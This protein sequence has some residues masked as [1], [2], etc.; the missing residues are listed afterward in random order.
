[1]EV[2]V[3]RLTGQLV[4]RIHS[5]FYFFIMSITYTITE[6][7][8][9]FIKVKYQDGKEITLGIKTWLSK[10]LIEAQIR[11]AYNEPDEGSVEDI[12]FKVG[13]TSTL[14][15]LQEREK[16]VLNAQ[17]NSNSVK[18]IPAIAMRD[19]SY[20]PVKLVLKAII[21][22]VLNNDKTDL[23]TIQTK[24]NEVDAKYPIENDQKYTMAEF[25]QARLNKG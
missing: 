17:N 1:M 21:K 22:A 20:P 6:V 10:G 23:E 18:N 7:T 14:Q 13:D 3:Q 11:N 9:E 8:K 12:P 19:V 5:N 16:E 24:Y 15:T 4:Q 2:G 25:E